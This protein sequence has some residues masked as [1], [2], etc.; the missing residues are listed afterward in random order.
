MSRR[1]FCYVDDLID[2]IISLTHQNDTPGPINIGNSG[3]FTVKELAERVVEMTGSQSQIVYHDLPEDDPKVR[4]PDLT[5][6]KKF[7]KYE[8]RIQLEDGLRKTIKYFQQE[9]SLS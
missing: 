8:P 3:E 1:S 4:R 7:L 2:G 6:A 5:N 9:L